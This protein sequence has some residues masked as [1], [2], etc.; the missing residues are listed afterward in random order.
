MKKFLFRLKH[1]TKRRV[2]CEYIVEAKGANEARKQM[3][4]NGMND[5]WRISKAFTLD[6]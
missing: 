5:K 2:S 4:R 1:R 6:D 3:N